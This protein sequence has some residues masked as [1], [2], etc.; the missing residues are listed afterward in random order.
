[1]SNSLLQGSIFILAAVFGAAGVAHA[2]GDRILQPPRK[3]L[4]AVHWPD[5]ANLEETVRDQITQ[6]QNSLA[7]GAKNADTSDT[8]L[9][10]AYANLG[11]LY[12]A[13]S[14]S[15]PARECYLNASTLAPGDFRW[16]YMLAKLDQQEGRFDDAIKRY[17]V[18]I[19]LQADY[20]AIHVNLGNIFLELNRPDDAEKS[21]SSALRIDKDNPAA[22]YGLGQVA[23]SNRSYFEAVTHFEQ[24]LTQVPGA[25]RVHYSLAMAYRRLGNTEKAKAHLAQQ[26]TVG[27]R[28]FDPMMD[29]LQELVTGERVY[30]SRGKVAFEAR[31][32]AEAATEFR[33]AVTAKPDS[34][35]AR[36]NLGA[37]LTQTGDLKGAAEQF[38][39]AIR[40]EPSRANAHYNLA[41]ILAGENKHELAINHLRSVLK[42][43]P[44]DLT[45][46]FL[47][48][49]ELK[50]SGNLDE[51]LSEYSR[52]VQAAPG[53][54]G[55]LLEQVKLLYRKKQ[56]KEALAGLEK[57]HDQY[58]QRGQTV[59]LLAYVLAASPQTDL[60]NG[61]RA[62]ELAERVY[63]STRAPEHGA[64]VAVAL[65][66]L[67]RCSEAAEWQRRMSAAAEQ[68]KNTDLLSKL[69]ASLKAYENSQSCRPE[70]ETILS[71][72]LFGSP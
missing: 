28:V 16:I 50:R 46:R 9:S 58:P 38:E 22:H 66:E 35:T 27:V 62:L 8:T 32:Y 4:V 71:D 15:D 64:L 57:S 3:E 12:H 40:I 10:D 48:A 14:L 26:G 51:A 31:R 60:R 7:A 24:T 52:V 59:L 69:R 25:N 23:M 29:G 33:K 43:E 44:N 30:L 13:Y 2:Q 41:V 17:R 6:A 19:L 63:N 34:V 1:M 11:Q 42:V 49:Q 67:G 54:E 53:N 36:I 70:N 45:A 72:L 68:N 39:E 56:F 21:F 18:A 20:I 61:T 47:L 55:A 5:L 65:A 37:A